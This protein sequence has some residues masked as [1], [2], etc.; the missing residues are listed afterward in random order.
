MG[1]FHNVALGQAGD[2]ESIVDSSIADAT[3]VFAIG[4]AGAILGLS[5]LSFVEKPK[6]HLKNILVGGSI[7]IIA[8]VVVVALRQAGL[9]REQYNS[10]QAH[11]SSSFTTV[12]RLAWHHHEH[13]RLNQKIGQK[14]SQLQ[15]AISF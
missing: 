11:N 7:G 12:D 4:A 2:N 10:S 8:G 3:T 9:S 14:R 15:Y 13:F 5:T 1:S 6:D